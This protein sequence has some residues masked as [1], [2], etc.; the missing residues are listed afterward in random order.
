MLRLGGQF[1]C[2]AEA[3]NSYRDVSL[4]GAG[5]IMGGLAQALGQLPPSLP[6]LGLSGSSSDENGPSPYADLPPFSGLR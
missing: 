1:K 2:G 5:E 6:D 3:A 4:H